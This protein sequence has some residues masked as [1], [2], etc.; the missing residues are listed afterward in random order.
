M[1]YVCNVTEVEGGEKEVN[2]NVTAQLTNVTGLDPDTTYKVDCVAYQSDG[3]EYCLA[4]SA[5][6]TTGELP[7]MSS[8]T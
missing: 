1:Y 3:V 2:K 5:T 8:Q 7:Q 4:A 6:V